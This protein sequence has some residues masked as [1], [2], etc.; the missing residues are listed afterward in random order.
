MGAF[1][2][3]T[4]TKLSKHIFVADKGDYYEIADGLPQDLRPPVPP[5]PPAST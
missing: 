5:V 2:G 4:R 3:P 1:E